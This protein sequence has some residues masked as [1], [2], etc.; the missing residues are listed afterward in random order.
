MDPVPHH[1]GNL[2][3][4]PHPHQSYKLDSEPNPDPQPDLDPH[5]PILVF[6][7]RV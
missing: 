6:L 1:F 2:H 3:P 4:D 7:K 5:E